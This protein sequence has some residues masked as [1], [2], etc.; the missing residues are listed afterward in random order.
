[1][2]GTRVGTRPGEDHPI[3]FEMASNLTLPAAGRLLIGRQ[4]ARGREGVVN[5]LR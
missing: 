1:L 3:Y 2:V 5:F 4:D